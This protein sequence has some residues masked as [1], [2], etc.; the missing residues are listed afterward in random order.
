MRSRYREQHTNGAKSEC[1][2]DEAVWGTFPASD[3]PAIGGVT[4]MIATP[5]HR[6]H[7]RKSSQIK[8]R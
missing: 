2:V 5:A 4:A 3:P 1:N 6:K 8:H 7:H